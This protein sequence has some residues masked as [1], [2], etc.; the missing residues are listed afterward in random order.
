MGEYYERYREAQ[1]DVARQK[2]HVR[3]LEE[4]L[5]DPLKHTGGLLF[6]YASEGHLKRVYNEAKERLERLK[7]DADDYRLQWEAYD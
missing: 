4:K 3:D 1:R 5:K 6:G 2:L 7:R